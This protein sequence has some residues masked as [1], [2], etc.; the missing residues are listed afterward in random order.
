MKLSKLAIVLSASLSAKQLYAEPL[1]ITTDRDAEHL[2]T[3]LQGKILPT[4]SLFNQPIYIAEIDESQLNALSR[5][6]HTEKNRCGGFMVHTSLASA[7]QATS[8]PEQMANFDPPPITQDERVN[9]AVATLSAQN[10]VDTIQTLSSYTNRYYSTSHGEKAAKWIKDDWASL[11]SGLSWA[12]AELYDHSWRQDSVVLTLTGSKYPDEI[13]VIGGHLDSTLNRGTSENSRAPGADDDASGIATIREALRAFLTL[14]EQPLRTLKFMGYAAEEIGL[15]GSNDIASN[16]RNNEKDVKAVM[17]LDM[18]NYKGSSKS[19]YFMTDYTDSN[20][21]NYS[22]SLMDHYFPNIE[23]GTS[24]CGYGCSDHASWNRK[25]YSAVMPFEASMSNSNPR[26]HTT[27]DTLSNSDTTGAHALNFAKLATA[28]LVEL[29][30]A[31]GGD[32]PDPDPDPDP[33]GKIKN[34]EPV[35][36]DGNRGS[37]T[38]YYIEVPSGVSQ[39]TVE[40]SGGSGDVD[41]YVRFGQKPT[42]NDYECRPYKWGNNETCQISNVKAGKYHIMLRGYSTYSDVKLVGKH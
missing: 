24:R 18:T 32:N 15:R 14:K 36:V 19:M 9:K 40:T 21:T 27:N 10:I 11:A 3:E 28:Y 5:R 31:D 13:I 37:E 22:K 17:Q 39:L 7:M 16:Y 12:N 6:M 34:G 20:L 41:L 33:D 1:W 38:Y 35:I 8:M 2:V 30:F 25:S 29:G 42:R 23:H 26:I 4:S